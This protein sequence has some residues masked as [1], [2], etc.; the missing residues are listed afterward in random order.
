MCSRT[1]ASRRGSAWV[2]V[3]DDLIVY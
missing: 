1:D 3:G 2:F